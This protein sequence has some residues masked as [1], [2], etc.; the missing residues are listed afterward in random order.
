M[1]AGTESAIR[2]IATPA[3]RAS[4]VTPAITA[5]LEKIR[6]PGRRL[7]PEADGEDLARLGGG[8]GVSFHLLPCRWKRDGGSRAWARDPPVHGLDQPPIASIAGWSS[9][10]MPGG[11][12]AEPA[13]SAATC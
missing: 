10:L 4:T 9:F 12:G 8:V 1:I 5:A 11:I 7:P 13:F 6:S 3:S 2:K